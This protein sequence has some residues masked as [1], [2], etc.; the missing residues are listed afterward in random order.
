M[1]LEKS[2]VSPS[3]WP[4]AMADALAVVKVG[5]RA[6]LLRKSTPSRAIAAMVGAV[7]SSTMRDRKPSATN[8]T[9]LCG[10]DAG[11][12]AEATDAGTAVMIAAKIRTGK[13]MNELPVRGQAAVLNKSAF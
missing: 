9:T 8:S 6:W 3:I 13:C 10:R 2:P 7:E 12:W 1:V 4:V 11:A 5:N